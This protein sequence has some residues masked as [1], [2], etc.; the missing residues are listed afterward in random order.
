MIL[1]A[2]V[3]HTIDVDGMLDRIST[4][5]FDE[6][7]ALY[8]LC[9]WAIGFPVPKSETTDPVHDSFNVFRAMTGV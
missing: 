9:P 1:A 4:E 6:W 2:T 7:L 8:N 5:Q 3:A